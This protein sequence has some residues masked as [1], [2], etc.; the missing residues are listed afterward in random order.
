[1]FGNDQLKMYRIMEGS[2]LPRSIG[3][4]C[5]LELSCSCCHQNAKIFSHHS[6]SQIF[7]LAENKQ[8]N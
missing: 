1:M 3:M 6:C 5:R 8:T 2:I 4:A 7:T